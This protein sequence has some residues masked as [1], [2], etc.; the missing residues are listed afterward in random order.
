MGSKKGKK[1]KAKG[2]A[3]EVEVVTTRYIIRER[4]R[5]MCPRLGDGSVRTDRADAV[6]LECVL[7]KLRRAILQKRTSLDLSHSK[8][9]FVPEDL[10]LSAPELHNLVELD[11]SRNQLFGSDHVFSSI[12]E[13]GSLRQLNLSDNFLNGPLSD[14]SL[15]LTTLDELILDC[16]QLTALPEN[17]GAW[18]R[19]KR[20]SAAT[21]SLTKIPDSI[22]EWSELLFLNL[23]MNK[24]TQL[25]IG[26]WQRV[27][28]LFLG[29]NELESL[30]ESV[31]KLVALTEL[32]LRSNHLTQL[33]DS[34]AACKN[35]K[36]LHLGSNRIN[37]IQPEIFENLKAIEE[38]HLYKNKLE[39]LPAELGCLTKCYRLSLSSNNI[40]TLPET[41][42]TCSSL[43]ELYINNCSRFTHMPNS[44]GSLVHLRE[45][46]ARKCQALKSLPSSAVG[47]EALRELDLRAAKKQVCKLPPELV[48]TLGA[49]NCVIRGGVFFF[50]VRTENFNQREIFALY[51]QVQKSKKS[52]RK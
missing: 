15:K 45:L 19:M 4:E 36:K 30:S 18:R 17:I 32:D 38:L 42:A 51:T 1:G 44:A 7:F 6:R 31:G 23:R 10:K 27:E 49:N 13:L 11:L 8:L 40:R 5:C 50:S 33:P 43:S 26:D 47:W 46:Q 2:K 34:L 35:L 39:K 14:C 22:I 37:E 12:A 20:F 48:P 16:N 21:N 41:I 28:A 3:S 29:G 25:A 52:S 24:L 9:G